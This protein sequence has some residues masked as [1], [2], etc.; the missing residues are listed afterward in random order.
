MSMNNNKTVLITG[1]A[2]FIGSNFVYKFLE[3]KY[4]VFVIEREGANLWRLKK[5]KSKIK[6]YS[7]NLLEY[8]KIEKCI[9]K[10]KP[11]IVL[12]FATYGAYQSK[13]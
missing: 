12:H 4:K 3:L 1:G 13:Q 2:G 9:N 10:I 7:P 11:N 6:V 5:I 8:D